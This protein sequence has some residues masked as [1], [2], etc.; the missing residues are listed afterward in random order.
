MTPGLFLV[1]RIN[2]FCALK[3]IFVPCGND[4]SVQNT[5]VCL[6]K[7]LL[8]VAVWQIPPIVPSSSNIGALTLETTRW[9]RLLR[10]HSFQSSRIFLLSSHIRDIDKE[11]LRS[12]TPER[13]I[14]ANSSNSDPEKGI[15]NQ[16]ANHEKIKATFAHRNL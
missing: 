4:L 8:V 6:V 15:Y 7:S 11:H 1:V 14:K 12:V 2:Y 13:A 10:K 9:H 3:V 5:F 16:N